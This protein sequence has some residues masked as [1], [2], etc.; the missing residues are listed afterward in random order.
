MK[1]SN[2]NYKINEVAENIMYKIPWMFYEFYSSYHNVV[3]NVSEC[4]SQVSC[5]E[6]HNVSISHFYVIL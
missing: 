2:F 6:N 3:E 4:S 5:G 1:C